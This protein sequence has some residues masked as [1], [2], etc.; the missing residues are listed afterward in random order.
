MQESGQ[1]VV[2]AAASGRIC[3]A[4]FVLSGM[5]S[6]SV[7]VSHSPAP[8]NPNYAASASAAAGQGSCRGR[9]GTLRIASIAPFVPAAVPCDELKRGIP[10]RRLRLPRLTCARGAICPR[11]RALFLAPAGRRRV[12]LGLL[13]IV[14]VVRAVPRHVVLQLLGLPPLRRRD[15]AG[16]RRRG[17]PRPPARWSGR[18]GVPAGGVRRSGLGRRR[19]V[20]VHRICVRVSARGRH[21]LLQEPRALLVLGEGLHVVLDSGVKD[22]LPFPLDLP[23]GHRVGVVVCPAHA[24]HLLGGQ[25]RRS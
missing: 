19:A 23:H 11:P 5:R 12:H 10:G 15:A 17:S 4:Q 6:L 18:H 21:L 16:S 22:V 2:K 3:K 20:P 1:A 8:D 14:R 24:Q 25:G 7:H 9:P 13:V